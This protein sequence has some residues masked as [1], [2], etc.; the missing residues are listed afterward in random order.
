MVLTRW[1]SREMGIDLGTANTLVTLKGRGIVLQEPSVIAVDVNRRPIAVG[2]EAKE[3]IGRTPGDIT[4]IRPLRDGVIADFDST[5][6][7]LLHFIRKVNRG[8]GPFRP[9]VVI[10]VPSGV[11]GVER[12]AVHDA[13]IQAGAREAF[14]IEEP[15]AAAIGAG[16]P[17]EEPRGSMVIGVG[18]GTTEVA[19]ISLGG[20]V[21]SRSIRVAG[22]KMDDAIISWI[23][24]AHSLLIGE[25]TAERIKMEIGSAM[26]G[27]RVG[28]VPVRGRDLLTGLPR[29]VDVTAGE[30]RSALAESVTAIAEAARA[31]LESTPPDL[32]SDIVTHG[33]T[34]TG[35]GA[36]LTGLDKLLSRET[37]VPVRVADDPMQCVVKGTGRVLEE[38]RILRHVMGRRRA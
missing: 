29:V 33:I 9:Q 38:V 1:F 37:G 20:L 14:I 5:K 35:G 15:L 25:T 11:T 13:V 4:A 23:K 27:T 7:M 2:N 6:A 28:S 21:V 17:V 30:I 22:N 34:L 3:M 16:L 12:R 8:R 10:S 19:V 32:A 24:R 26:E 31:T 36:Q 18:G